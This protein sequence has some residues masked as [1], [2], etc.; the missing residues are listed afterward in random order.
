[1][2]K[3]QN[4]RYSAC[5]KGTAKLNVKH[6]KTGSTNSGNIRCMDLLI[7]LFIA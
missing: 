4:D 3:S 2:K 5:T 1:M 6:I 7:F